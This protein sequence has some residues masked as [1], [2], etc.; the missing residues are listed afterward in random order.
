MKLP[1][2]TTYLTYLNVTDYSIAALFIPLLE[3]LHTLTMFIK[4]SNFVYGM[5][6]RHSKS[7]I[8]LRLKGQGHRV[9]KC[10]FSH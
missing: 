10:I 8:V 6:L 9:N 7:D 2:V 5:T 1:Q 4:F 3:L